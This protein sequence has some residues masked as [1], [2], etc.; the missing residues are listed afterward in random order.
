[1]TIQGLA[2]SPIDEPDAIND[3]PL[4]RCLAAAAQGD[5]DMLREAVAAMRGGAARTAL[6]GL[7]EQQERPHRHADRCYVLAD[8]EKAEVGRNLSE[9]VGSVSAV[10]GMAAPTVLLDIREHGPALA[11]AERIGADADTGYIRIPPAN[12]NPRTLTH[13][14]V[15]CSLQSGNRV[16][17]EGLADWVADRLHGAPDRSALLEPAALAA[18]LASP[19]L[20]SDVYFDATAP[21]AEARARLRN[22]AVGVVEAINARG[23][24]DAIRTLYL[25]GAQLAPKAVVA[26]FSEAAAISLGVEDHDAA[27]ATLRENLY[28]AQIAGDR[29]ALRE[30]A[31]QSIKLGRDRQDDWRPLDTAVVALLAS[32]R[33]TV[34]VGGSEAASTIVVADAWLTEAKA[35]GLPPSRAEALA[36]H[37][38]MVGWIGALAGGIR[39][40]AIVG[41]QRA[42]RHFREALVLDPDDRDAD[43]ALAFLL[44]AAKRP[45]EGGGGRL[46]GRHPQARPRLGGAATGTVLDMSD[47]RVA[48]S[49][50]FELVIDRFVVGGGERIALVGANGSGK[51]TL[52]DAILGLAPA[53]GRYEVLGAPVRRAGLDPARRLRIGALL[54][55]APLPRTLT[56]REAIRLLDGV[57]GRA[58]PVVS[59]AMG[60]EELARKPVSTLSRGQNQR[61]MVY[62]ALGHTPDLLLLDEASLGLDGQYAGALRRLLFGSWG[63]GKTLLICSHL[64]MDLDKVDR[65][66]LMEQGRIVRDG[67]ASELIKN[68]GWFWRGTIEGIDAVACQTLIEDLPDF[69]RIDVRPDGVTAFG[70][71]AFGRA[72]AAFASTQ[73]ARSHSVAQATIQDVVGAV[74]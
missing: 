54:N 63:H 40:R 31:T 60:L 42:E 59:E 17:D 66:V 19:H 33:E 36:G 16:L 18:A 57:F 39:A 65:V 37:R 27:L 64:P 8:A 1:M 70:G 5:W 14:I 4:Q 28:A 12:V 53:S 25:S 43:A 46:I 69:Q 58:D 44:N 67:A 50:G 15:H 62:A 68:L 41:S 24:I 20:S 13:E 21:T 72:F 29:D 34:R 45:D 56:V 7:V 48:G 3:T 47:L 35:R 52:L 9:A 22:S 71:P 6:R 74:R 49:D 10:L 51:S 23:G 32:A 11:F 38:A 26:A 73:P 61:V 30:T 55:Q 2:T